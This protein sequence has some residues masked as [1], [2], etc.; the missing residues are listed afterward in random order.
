[1]PGDKAYAEKVL[2]LI[3]CLIPHGRYHGVEPGRGLQE[4][5]AGKC[6]VNQLDH[7]GQSD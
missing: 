4:H 5:P 7:T 3:P 1:M 2:G 6:A